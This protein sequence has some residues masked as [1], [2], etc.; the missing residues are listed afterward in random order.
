MRDRIT[1]TIV[2]LGIIAFILTIA[3]FVEIQRTERYAKAYPAWVKQTGNPKELTFEEWRAIKESEKRED[4]C[5]II[6]PMYR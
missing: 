6:M 1:F 2:V 3:Y 5:L 4:S